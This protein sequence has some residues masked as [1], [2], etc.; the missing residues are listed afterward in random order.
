M[1]ASVIAVHTDASKNGKPLVG[2]AFELDRPLRPWRA[3]ARAFHSAAAGRR[4][5]RLRGR[6]WRHRS[7]PGLGRP[8]DGREA[9][10]PRRAMRRGWPAR[11]GAV[12]PCREGRG[13]AAV[14][15][16]GA[17]TTATPMRE[18]QDRDLCQRRP[19]SAA[20]RHRRRC[21]TTCAARSAQGHRRF[22]IK[23]GGASL[24]ADLRAHRGG[25][26][27][28]RARHE[29]RGR[30]QR[31]IRSRQDRSD[32]S[33]RS[34]PIRWPGSKSRSIRSTSSCIATSRRD[35]RSAARDRRELFSR[36]DARNLLR[37]ADCARIATSCSSTS[38]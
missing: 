7:A 33:K 30:R 18:R 28:A 21:A 37:Y 5:G 11:C 38:R 3:A 10:R 31:H 25:V 22:K 15:A 34:S 8:D 4:S 16:A 1:T 9:G 13:R 14:E 35:V 17:T 2:L 27:R 12:G 29:S 19:L 32:I 26:R 24:A 23:I 6:Q 36:D 20:E